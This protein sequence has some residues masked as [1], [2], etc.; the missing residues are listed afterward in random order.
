MESQGSVGAIVK[1][2]FG[3]PRVFRLIRNNSSLKWNLGNIN[4]LFKRLWFFYRE[5][6]GRLIGIA[7]DT[8]LT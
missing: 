1:E 8:A 7:S 4:P 5:L 3:D 6:L 2:V